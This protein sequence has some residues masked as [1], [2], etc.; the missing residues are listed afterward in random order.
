EIAFRQRA[1]LMRT[2]IRHGKELTLHIEDDKLA[3]PHRD[4]LTRPRHNIAGRRDY[5]FRQILF[6]LFPIGGIGNFWYC[7]AAD[8]RRAADILGLRFFLHDLQHIENAVAWN[9]AD[10]GIVSN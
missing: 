4:E 2:T 8:D 10:A 3:A 7:G 9:E 6:S 1:A 5:V